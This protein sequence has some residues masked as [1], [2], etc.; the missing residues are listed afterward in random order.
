MN[1][2]S[3]RTLCLLL[4]LSLLP[5]TYGC[6]DKGPVK[7]SWGEMKG[8]ENIVG[9]MSDVSYSSVRTQAPRLNALGEPVSM[10]DFEGSFVWA[11]Y[12]AP[13]CQPCTWQAP[14]AKIVEKE[15]GSEIVFLTIM[16]SK[17]TKYDDHATVDTAAAW[18]R[19]HGLDVHRVLAAELWYKT[20]PEHRFYS[21]QGHTLFVHVGTLTA[22][23]I[24]QVIA[25]YRAE[26]EDWSRS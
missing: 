26:W 9:N 13:W 25:Y 17:S 4:V 5:A 19:R 3:T 10:P 6:G 14:Q 11:E 1:P 24:R 21:P 7:R 15:M 12:A 18:A 8:L 22:D 23:Q 20:V 16:T 2:R